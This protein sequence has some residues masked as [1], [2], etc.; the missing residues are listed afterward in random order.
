[1]NSP[2]REV[3]V[4]AVCHLNPHLAIEGYC[5]TLKLT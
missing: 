3:G 2:H 5:D 1:M 4:I